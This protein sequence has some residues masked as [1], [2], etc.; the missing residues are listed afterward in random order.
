MRIGVV[1]FLYQG[2]GGLTRHSETVLR[3]LSEAWA[4]GGEDEFIVF[5]HDLRHPSL[6]RLASGRNWSV[7]PLWGESRTWRGTLAAVGRRLWR[8]VR[9]QPVRPGGRPDAAGPDPWG[10]GRPLP[11][12]DVP[13][14][15]TDWDRWL[16][17]CGAELLL[18]LANNAFPF[19]AGVPY[20][21]VVHDL[22]HRLQ[23]EFPEVSEGGEW[24]WREY[25]FRNGVRYA[26]LVVTESEVGKEDVSSCY[27]EWGVTPDR[28]R[29][30]PN[31]PAPFGPAGAA[32]GERVR[33]KYRLP[34][35]YLFY[36]AQFWPHKNHARVV[37]ALGVLKRERDLRVPL[38]CCGSWSGE[39]RER[40]FREV[41][42]LVQRHGLDG[43]VFFLDYVPNDDMAGLYVGAAALVFPTFFGPT[44]IP[45]LEAWSVGCPV[46][47]S[48][49][50]GLREQAGDAAILVDPRSVTALA[51]GM[52]R[53]WTDETLRSDLV[54][55]GR[56]RV[57]SY[58]ARDFS[59]RLRGIVEEAKRRVRAGD[60][61]RRS[62]AD[63][64]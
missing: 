64:A 12:P 5:T 43:Q 40:T 45:P 30:L 21:V 1:P 44:N 53:L 38:V 11:D 29:V 54:A 31:L 19:E 46:L 41:G 23:P 15:N 58:T 49:I 17:S 33:G 51:E 4:D 34:R 55:R 24:E 59:D 48:D 63:G 62:A 56:A 32:E 20:V 10:T 16:K 6:S 61:P 39:I 25:F 26:T 2:I 36:P 42:E 50:R 7:K 35:R 8:R 28:V 22:Q 27:G 13:Q 3:A 57:A 60:F 52:H 14:F 18:V 9:R 47:T 37:E